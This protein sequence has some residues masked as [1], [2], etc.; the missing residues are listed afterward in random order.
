[1]IGFGT[2]RTGTVRLPS[3]PYLGKAV[4]TFV[5]ITSCMHVAAAILIAVITNRTT[6]KDNVSINFFGMSLRAVKGGTHGM[7][8]ATCC[9]VGLDTFSTRTLDHERILLG[10]ES[11]LAFHGIARGMHD[12]ASFG[13]NRLVTNR[14]STGDRSRF[15][16]L[17][18][19]L[20]GA[21]EGVTICFEDTASIH[22][23]LSAL[24]SRTSNVSRAVNECVS[25]ATHHGI[26]KRVFLT[27]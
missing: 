24:F 22:I 26:T 16:T 6:A 14:S 23:I 9:H 2:G 19:T 15:W 21:S 5:I 10:G 27:T 18:L 8:F 25:F 3:L 20:V 11:V 7:L 1:M 17:A 12:T 13:I 4:W